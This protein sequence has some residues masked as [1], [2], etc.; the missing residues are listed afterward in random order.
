MSAAAIATIGLGAVKL[1]T[2]LMKTA[3][4]SDSLVEVTKV[5]RV[6]PIVLID[7]DCMF[8][9]GLPDLMQS[10]QSIFC[11]YYLQ[12]VAVTTTVGNISVAGKLG[13]LNPNRDPWS[14]LGSSHSYGE[15]GASATV[16]KTGIGMLSRESYAF[17]LPSFKKANISAGLEAM[18]L[19][20]EVAPSYKTKAEAQAEADKSNAS[21][22]DLKKKDKGDQSNGKGFSMSLGRD[23]GQNIAE[24]SNLSVGKMLSVEITDGNAKAT[25]PVSVR[26]LA[27]S[28][29]TNSLVHIL[30]PS[31]MDT[32][33]KARWHAWKA[34]RLET[35]KDMIFCQ[36]LIDAHR[37]KI[38]EDNTGMFTTILN[39][40]RKNQLATVVS[41]TPSVATCSNML[42]M[43]DVTQA[44][45][46]LE[47]NL[48]LANFHDRQKLFDET[49]FMIMA[50]IDKRWDRV[51][52]YTRSIPETT[53]VTFR[54]MKIGNR[55][56]GPD[57]AEILK[58]Y[59]LG[60]SPSI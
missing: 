31:E 21:N 11:G 30:S 27:N 53:T 41:G 14:E 45:L 2:D 23:L 22:P 25:I 10:L 5:M 16:I 55:G 12:A 35:V 51:T 38:L 44:K 15:I 8:H 52:I 42:V 13:K 34:G 49:S 47:S 28:I 40:K 56:N 46:E 18:H 9:E 19:G 33:W 48:R 1:A 4:G 59:Q 3:A 57:I 7:S 24:V 20:M 17:G 36:D 60:H 58:A 54:D 37:K 39:R 43:S 32:T 29:P 50:V 26:L 6:E